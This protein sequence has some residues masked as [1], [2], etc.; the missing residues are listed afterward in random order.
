MGS[1]KADKKRTAPRRPT[2]RL[3]GSKIAV[4]K[5]WSHGPAVRRHYWAKHREVMTA[6]HEN[7]RVPEPASRRKA[8]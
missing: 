3:C 8:R 5:G 1:S 4:P 7:R 2:C 6:G